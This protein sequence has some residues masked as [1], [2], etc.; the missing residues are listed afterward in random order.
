MGF[1]YPNWD[2]TRIR[3]SMEERTVEKL[4]KLKEWLSLPDA[5]QHLSILFLSSVRFIN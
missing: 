3:K 1:P 5:A 4:F 2:Q